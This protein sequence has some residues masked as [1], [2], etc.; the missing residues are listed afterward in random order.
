MLGGSEPGGEVNPLGNLVV[1]IL[2]PVSC[3]FGEGR[4]YDIDNQQGTGPGIVRA[5]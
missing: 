5:R 1:R 2:G 3:L 4:I